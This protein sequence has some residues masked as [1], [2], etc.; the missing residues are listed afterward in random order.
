LNRDRKGTYCVALN[1]LSGCR[2]ASSGAQDSDEEDLPQLENE[3]SVIYKAPEI[4]KSG[5]SLRS[6]AS[7]IWSLGVL[8]YACAVG[9][10]PFA[11]VEETL[12]KP[13][14]WRYADSAKIK[15][16]EEFKQL[17]SSMLNKEPS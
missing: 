12:S 2:L 1:G 7:D 15:L 9:R 14:N 5:G 11:N 8:V 17:V 13:L 16:S 4:V 10:L 3:W 6:P